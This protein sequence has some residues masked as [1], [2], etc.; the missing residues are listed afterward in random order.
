[1]HKHASSSSYITF[2]KTG[3][4][5]ILKNN[6]KLLI[7]TTNTKIHEN[8]YFKLLSLIKFNKLLLKDLSELLC[9]IKGGSLLKSS[10]PL[11]NKEFLAANELELIM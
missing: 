8:Q 6:T 7:L 9:L 5:T 2:D 11:T 10:K 3:E 4:Q 1:M